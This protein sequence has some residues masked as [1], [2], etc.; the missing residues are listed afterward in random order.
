MA[1]KSRKTETIYINERLEQELLGDP[2]SLP[3]C[4][5]TARQDAELVSVFLEAYGQAGMDIVLCGHA[6]GGQVRLPW[7]GG[8]FAPGQ[9]LLPRLTS[10]VHKKNGTFMVVS[11]GLGNSLAPF[12]IL[13]HPETVLITLKTKR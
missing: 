10:G 13:N 4:A 3:V 2:L 12:R 1:R 6:H 5:E 7:I 9:G 8:L 11:R